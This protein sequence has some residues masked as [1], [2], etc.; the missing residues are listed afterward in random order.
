[1][2]WGSIDFSILESRN[3]TYPQGAFV[4]ARMETWWLR[5]RFVIGYPILMH[6]PAGFD[7]FRRLPFVEHKC[8]LHPDLLSSAGGEYGLIGPGCLPVSRSRCPVGPSPVRVLPVPWSEEIP[9]EFPERGL[10]C[11]ILDINSKMIEQLLIKKKKVLFVCQLFPSKYLQI[12]MGKLF[13][14]G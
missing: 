13:F 5:A 8:F 7:P 14:E 6:D 9:F 12:V 10:C 11:K 4:V 3:D 2:E 1:M